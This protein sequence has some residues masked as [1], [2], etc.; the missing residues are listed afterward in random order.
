[1]NKLFA[2]LKWHWSKW[3]PGQRVYILSAGFIGAGIADYWE[4]GI[5][6]LPMRI[7]FGMMLAVLIKWFFWDTTIASWKRFEEERKDLFKTIK[8]SEHASKSN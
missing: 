3:T 1:M 6:N 2:F 8:E 4:S 5:I 7:G